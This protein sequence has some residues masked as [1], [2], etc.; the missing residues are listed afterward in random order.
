MRHS[1]AILAIARQAQAVHT[2]TVPVAR[3]PPE[4]RVAAVQAG[5]AAAHP[6]SGCRSGGGLG[7]T[8]VLVPRE[9][10]IRPAA[11][12]QPAAVLPSSARPRP[13]V[14]D[15]TGLGGGVLMAVATK[16]AGCGA[17]GGKTQ[18]G[19]TKH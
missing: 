16:R 7:D 8:T 2:P 3:R 18:C 4:R 1:A 11:P 5:P 14:N 10:E 17:D 13:V 15:A 6:L 9:G 12:G 19:G